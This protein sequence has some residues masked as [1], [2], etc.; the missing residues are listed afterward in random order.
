MNRDDRGT[1]LIEGVGDVEDGHGQSDGG[2]QGGFGEVHARADATAET[3]AGAAGVTLD[4]LPGTG[5]KALRV[6]GER[7]GPDVGVVEDT[8]K[9]VQ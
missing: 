3:E 9:N 5:D 4:F 1:A 6:E 7:L 8:P 2:E